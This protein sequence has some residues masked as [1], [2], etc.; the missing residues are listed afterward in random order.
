MRKRIL[1]ALL[2]CLVLMQSA[3]AYVRI[4]TGRDASLS[5]D[6]IHSGVTFH[7]YRVADV[8]E[9][10]RFTLCGDF[11]RYTDLQPLLDSSAWDDLALILDARVVRDGIRPTASGQTNAKADLTFAGLKPGLYLM[12]GD[13]YHIGDATYYPKTT[14]VCVPSLT[15]EDA[16]QYDPV[17]RPKYSVEEKP[18]TPKTEVSVQKIWMDDG[19]E[20]ERPEAI[21]VQLMKD[22]AAVETAI[23]SAANNWRW[24]WGDLP[25]GYYYRV[26]ETNIADGYSDSYHREGSTVVIINTYTEEPEE[27]EE[28][29]I[30]IPDDEPPLDKPESPEKPAQPTL[31]QTGQ[32][33]WPVP[34]LIVAGM[35]LILIGLIRRRG[36]VNEE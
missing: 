24:H 16:W 34:L 29:P 27:P 31:P 15:A 18:E 17:I 32:L 10:V 5:I 36:A 12:M 28:P 30:E 8:S 22:G 9:T 33:W 20:E 1:A 26:V 14:L 25:A 3:A 4:E 19:F 2:V 7:I 23:L 21:T 13:P 11:A 6:H 35:T